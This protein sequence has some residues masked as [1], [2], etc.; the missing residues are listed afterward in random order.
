MLNFIHLVLVFCV[1]N[2][3]ISLEELSIFT[4]S[5]DYYNPVVPKTSKERLSSRPFISGDSF[6]NICDHFFD[7]CGEILDLNCLQDGD[8]VYVTPSALN[9]FFLDIHPRIKKKYILLTHNSDDSLPGV[10]EGYLKDENLAHWFTTNSSVI[11]NPKVTAIPIGIA[12]RYWAHGDVG[13]FKKILEKKIKKN[14][15][16]CMNFQVHTCPHKRQ[17]IFEFFKEKSFCYNPRLKSLDQYLIDI[18]SSIF[19]IS[20]PGNGLDCHRTWEAL[21]MGTIPIVQSSPINELFKDLPVL[22]IEDYKKINEK[23]LIDKIADIKL[24]G[25]KNEKIFFSYWENLVLNKKN[26]IKEEL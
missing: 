20:P 22:I 12:N 5:K 1:F 14:H 21:V 18:K 24:D 13:V 23:D 8:L 7:E 16:L 6:R 10:F 4:L 2:S 9:V 11:N 26:Q 17:P 3:L 15:L 25:F 19:L